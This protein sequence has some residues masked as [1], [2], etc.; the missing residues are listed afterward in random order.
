MAFSP[1]RRRSIS[2]EELNRQPVSARSSFQPMHRFSSGTFERLNGILLRSHFTSIFSA[3]KEEGL[4]DHEIKD[5]LI[6]SLNHPDW[7]RDSVVNWTRCYAMFIEDRDLTRFI[8]NL[9]P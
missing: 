5:E 9:M 6:S 4:I 1:H 2:R 8:N 7:V 3:M